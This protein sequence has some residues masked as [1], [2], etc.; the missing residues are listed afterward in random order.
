MEN[1]ERFTALPG[2]PLERAWLEE[3]LKT[4]SVRE[5][6]VLTA[7]AAQHSPESMAEAVRCLRSLDDYEVCYPADSYLQ[8]GEF[9]LGQEKALPEEVRPYLDLEQLGRKYEDE[10]PGL[11]VGD[12]Y[13]IYPASAICCGGSLL[14]GDE[15]WS[16]K[17]KLAS[18]SCPNGV[19]LRLPDYTAPLI[20]GSVE[21][22]MALNALR[23]KA[24][25]DCTLLEAHCILPEV[26]D[27]MEQYS[28][29][30]ELVRDGNNLGYALGEQGEG[31]HRWIERFA[32]AL[33]YE[34]CRT[35]RF[36]LDISQNLHCY[37]WVPCDE[38]SEYGAR[39]L[40]SCGVSKELVE[41]GC[42]DLK[43]YAEDM[44]EV[45]GYY[46][47]EDESAYVARNDL[48]FFYERST[49]EQAPDMT[50]E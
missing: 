36:A 44:L 13:V 11:F 18:P 28:S 22:A 46:L 31:A 8:L 26:D 30:P 33:E 5:S 17:L 47:T 9:C 7:A 6:C 3:R 48:E 15:T 19:W 41:S 40:R 39:H 49:P 10:H 43:G 38:L 42:I 2:T 35:L 45:S 50:M 16:V 34:D 27:L 25:E 37:D 12:C 1:F 32:A 4:L 21:V 14:R 20:D 29:I 23:V 24:L